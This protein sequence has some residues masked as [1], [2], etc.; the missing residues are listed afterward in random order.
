MRDYALNRAASIEATGAFSLIGRVIGN[1]HAR[2]AVARL[3][4]F[5]DYLL[6]DIGVTRGDVRWASGLPLSVNAALELEQRSIQRRK[7]LR[8]D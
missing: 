8:N 6:R 3:D 5:D 1:W 7:G 4:T 2:R